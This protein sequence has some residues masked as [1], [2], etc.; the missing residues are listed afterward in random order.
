[1]RLGT[2]DSNPIRVARSQ[3]ADQDAGNTKNFEISADVDLVNLPKRF[4]IKM[5]NI[6]PS[7]IAA[8]I[9]RIF[10]KA[11]RIIIPGVSGY[12]LVY[13]KTVAAG[14]GLSNT[15]AEIS[16]VDEDASAN[17]YDGNEDS[18]E[19]KAQLFCQIVTKTGVDVDYDVAIYFIQ[20]ELSVIS[21]DCYG[22]PKAIKY[23]YFFIDNTTQVLYTKI[24]T[25]FA[26]KAAVGADGFLALNYL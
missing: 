11:T 3:V 15:I 19:Y 16:Y 20:Q 18:G 17:V 9:F 6:Q 2:R 12:S 7:S 22:Q 8:Y 24:D 5:L 21:Y 25:I 13:E 26:P 1:M 14:T 10:S 23:C 4:L